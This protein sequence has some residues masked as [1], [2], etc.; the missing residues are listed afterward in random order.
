MLAFCLFQENLLARDTYP[1][2]L[3][4]IC[5]QSFPL[6]LEVYGPCWESLAS[7]TLRDVCGEGSQISK[8]IPSHVSPGTSMHDAPTRHRACDSEG[9]SPHKWCFSCGVKADLHKLCLSFWGLSYIG[10]FIYFTIMYWRKLHSTQCIFPKWTCP[11][12]QF[13]DKT[14]NLLVPYKIPQW[15]LLVT[16]LLSL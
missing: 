11:C 4:L 9:R 13:L 12:N 1:G 3:H 14:Q 7:P 8:Q 10:L 5:Q 6:L 2:W 15:S 16:L